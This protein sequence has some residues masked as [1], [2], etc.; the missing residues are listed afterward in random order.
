VHPRIVLVLV[1]CAAAAFAAMA[2][3]AAALVGTGT[4]GA[5]TEVSAPVSP[6]EGS[7]MPPGVRAPDFALRD[8]D[9]A[10]VRMRDYRGRPAIVTF[11]YTNCE[12]SCPPQVQQVKGA[13]NELG[14]DVPALAITVDPARDTARSARAFLAEQRMTGRMSFALGTP[15]QLRTVFRGFAIQPQLAD[16]EHQ[17]RTVLIDE[18]GFQR[19]GYFIDQLTPERLAHDYRVLA[20]GGA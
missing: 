4:Q 14:E 8:Q 7:L 5:A 12:E 16:A 10:P 3:T 9:G 11:V 20:S 17:S 2:L 18:R 15:E 1:V 6:F 13:M 19:V